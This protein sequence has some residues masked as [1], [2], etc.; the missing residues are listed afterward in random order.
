MMGLVSHVRAD[1]DLVRVERVQIAVP[2]GPVVAH[3][4]HT[5]PGP[6]VEHGACHAYEDRT[7]DAMACH[8][9][10]GGHPNTPAAHAHPV[11]TRLGFSASSRLAP[12]LASKGVGCELDEWF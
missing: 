6:V 1:E 8:R 3:R 5:A 10:C 2:R 4:R 12:V 7:A 9:S 11:R